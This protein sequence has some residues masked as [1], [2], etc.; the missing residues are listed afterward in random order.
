MGWPQDVLQQAMTQC[1]DQGGQISSCSVL[2]SRSEQEMNDCA[3]PPRVEE[4]VDGCTFFQPRRCVFTHQ[5]TRCVGLTAL[6]GCNPIQTG[7]ANATPVSG[8]GATTATKAASAVSWLKK[9]IDGWQ[10]VGCAAEPQGQNLLTGGTTTGGGMTVEKCLNNCATKGFKFAGL[11]NKNVCSCGNSFDASKVSS[12]YACN[13][14]CEGNLNG[15][16]LI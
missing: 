13:L 3:S 7:P 9:D 12:A 1:T 6:P 10:A 5:P 2:H 8:C 14:A 16:Q 4:N 11:K 15:M